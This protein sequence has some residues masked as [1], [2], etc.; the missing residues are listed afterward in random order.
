MHSGYKEYYNVTI[1]KSGDI[2]VNG[3]VDLY[4]IKN[5]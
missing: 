1:N 3:N 4:F 5:N 2:I